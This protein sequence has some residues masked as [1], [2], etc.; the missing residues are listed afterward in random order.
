M[1]NKDKKDGEKEDNHDD[2]CTDL[3]LLDIPEQTYN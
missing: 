2:H 3:A 1:L